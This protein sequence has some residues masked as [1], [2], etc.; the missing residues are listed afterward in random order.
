LAV[1]CA[2]PDGLW[3]LQYE[4]ERDILISGS[5]DTTI[6]VWNMKTYTCEQTLSGHT[7][8]PL[9]PPSHFCFQG[10]DGETRRCSIRV[11]GPFGDDHDDKVFSMR[12]AQPTY[13][14]DY[15]FV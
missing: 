12:K 8:T 14:F 5:R 4:N 7:G 15:H 6:K 1:L 2:Q 13:Y 10:V 9:L 11:D 3:T